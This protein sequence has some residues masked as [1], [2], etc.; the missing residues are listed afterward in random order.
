MRP[1]STPAYAAAIEAGGLSE[2]EPAISGYF[3]PNYYAA[4]VG[5]FDGNH[6]EIVH[7]RFN[8]LASA[9]PG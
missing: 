1:R 3:G 4:N 6:I 5:D 8:P 7:K 9:S 2:G